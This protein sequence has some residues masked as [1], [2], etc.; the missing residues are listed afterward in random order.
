MAVTLSGPRRDA[1]LVMRWPRLG[2]ST[3]IHGRALVATLGLALVTFAVFC[4]SLTSGEID[5][6][7]NEVLGALFTTGSPESYFV[8]RTL[9]LPRALTGLLVGAAFGLSG[10][11]FQ[12]L[13]RNPATTAANSSPSRVNLSIEPDLG[14]V[15][16]E[17]V[18]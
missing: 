12:R 3:R 17:M 5:V 7:L 10:A 15:L 18:A 6:P 4:W 16:S 13:A 2:W 14:E 1:M 8:I 11:I 9:R